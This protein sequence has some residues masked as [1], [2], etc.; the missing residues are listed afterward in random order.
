MWTLQ[1]ANEWVTIDQ[2][3]Q[4]CEYLNLKGIN[5]DPTFGDGLQ[6]FTLGM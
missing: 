4:T 6:N 1:L 3:D 5:R 2:V